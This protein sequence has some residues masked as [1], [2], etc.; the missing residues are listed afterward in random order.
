VTDVDPPLGEKVTALTL[1]LREADIPFAFGGAI[2]LAYYAEPRATIDL[3]VNV[4]VPESDVERVTTALK[5]LGIEATAAQRKTVARDGQVRLWWGPVTPVDLFFA[6]DEFHYS[7]AKRV[8]TVP[9]GDS[10][11]PILA[12]E[13][14]MVCKVVFDR[15][16]DWIDIEQAL[17]LLAG[18][19]DV[20]NI[21]SWVVRIV[22]PD[23]PRVAK[24]DDAVA[25][26]QGP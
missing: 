18:E 21:R 25:R 24:W 22:G 5:P 15:A 17:V 9:F 6:Y 2:A 13:D 1:R 8:R 26:M 3:D 4:F 14:L 20:A 10:S 11:I 16:K 23:D 7:A 19:L 12:A